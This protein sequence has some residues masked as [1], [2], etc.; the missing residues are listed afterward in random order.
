MLSTKWTADS[1]SKDSQQINNVTF[2]VNGQTETK[3]HPPSKKLRGPAKELL[4]RTGNTTDL[5]EWRLTFEGEE[6]DFDS[7]FGEENIPDG[8][9]LI[10]SQA[11]P[12]HKAS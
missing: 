5:E 12:G 3:D 10:L 9:T 1:M 8:A 11:D 6:L 2:D 7:T 4:G